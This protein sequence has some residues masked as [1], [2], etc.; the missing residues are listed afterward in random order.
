MFVF[1]I[2]FQL[3]Q[4]IRK[5]RPTH[6][7][8]EGVVI[9]EYWARFIERFQLSSTS[10]MHL[11]L[12][13]CQMPIAVWPDIA[14]TPIQQ[15]DV[16]HCRFNEECI[17]GLLMMA[18]PKEVRVYGRVDADLTEFFNI[19]AHNLNRLKTV[20]LY[21]VTTPH[22]YR[23]GNAIAFYL[24]VGNLVAQNRPITV[25]FNSDDFLDDAEMDFV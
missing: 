9:T 15:V 11:F 1:F 10:K 16:I 22:F 4:I 20:F 25:V 6:L 23:H 8:M 7:K 2:I 17:A 21:D 13:D 24:F 14:M 12:R 19:L 5:C 3:W 18:S